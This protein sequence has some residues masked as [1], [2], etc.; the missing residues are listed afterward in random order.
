MALLSKQSLIFQ[1][2]ENKFKFLKVENDKNNK[3]VIADL[4]E[5]YW[6]RMEQTSVADPVLTQA[7]LE[8][9]H[10][11]SLAEAIENFKEKRNRAHNF[12]EDT[13]ES[14]LVK[15]KTRTKLLSFCLKIISAIGRLSF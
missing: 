1:S 5:V 3:Q 6:Q 10:N 4:R 15:V 8:K 13:Y 7:E 2:L 11:E 9:E 14:D 12:P